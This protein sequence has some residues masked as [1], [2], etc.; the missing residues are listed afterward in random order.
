MATMG[1]KQNRIDHAS[2]VSERVEIEDVKLLQ[3]K[4]HYH[5]TGEKLPD[6]LNVEFH[7]KTNADQ[8]SLSIHVVVGFRLTGIFEGASP[9]D[10]PLLEIEAKFLLLYRVSSLEGLSHRNL[11]AFGELNGL[12]NAYPYL[13]EF[14]QSTTSRMGLPP[15]VIP[16]LKPLGRKATRTRARSGAASLANVGKT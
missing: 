5:P 12:Y 3:S 8:A 7:V 13:R 10:E 15:L 16:V 4:C 11:K 9:K 6:K 14:V 2:A 1:R